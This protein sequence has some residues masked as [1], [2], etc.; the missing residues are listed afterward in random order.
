[1]FGFFNKTTKE[2]KPTETAAPV[3]VAEKHEPAV[4]VATAEE[5]ELAAD[6][7]AEYHRVALTIGF[8]G[9]GALFDQ[10]LERFLLENNIHTYHSR[11]VVPYLDKQ[12]GNDWV[13]AGLR[14]TDTEHLTGWS[15]EMG[16]RRVSFGRRTYRGAVP[17][18]VL[19]TVQT[20]QQ[21]FPEAHFYV[22]E[23]AKVNGDPFL[24]VASRD[25]GCYIV[26]RWDEPGF[27]ER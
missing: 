17:L 8:E 5:P 9:N 6:E 7:L 14:P 2:E 10:R 4:P 25:G 16:G 27:R 22:S 11:D 18:P 1:M 3:A 24:M 19:L 26:E 20:I 23:T 13:W 15:S 12:L 21:A